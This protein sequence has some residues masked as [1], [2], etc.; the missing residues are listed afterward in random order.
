VSRG[1]SSPIRTIQVLR[2]F[3]NSVLVNEIEIHD[4]ALSVGVRRT[5]SSFRLARSRQQGRPQ[6]FRIGLPDSNG[7]EHSRFVTIPRMP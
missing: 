3:C 2:I 6:N 5:Q 1:Q 4:V 7:G